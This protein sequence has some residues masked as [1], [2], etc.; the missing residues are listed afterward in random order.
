M[1][2]YSIQ[3]GF[4]GSKAEPEVEVQLRLSIGI[5]PDEIDEILEMSSTCQNL[6][7][8]KLSMLEQTVWE[9][10]YNSGP[11]LCTFIKAHAVDGANQK[12]VGFAVYNE[13]AAE[14]S[15]YE[16]FLIAVHEDYRSIGIGA[17]LIDEVERHI[18]V[19]EGSTVFCELPEDQDY[20]SAAIFL[21]FLGYT[22]Q[23]RHYKFF[24]PEPG[25]TVYAK[26]II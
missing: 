21:N 4:G 22:R 1:N 24:I 3:E 20:E 2:S 18:S 12:L 14:E 10:A 6:S 8:E 26:R 9:E 15:C 11:P 16:L 17:A 13:I 7:Q 23:T 19:E 5:A 25:N